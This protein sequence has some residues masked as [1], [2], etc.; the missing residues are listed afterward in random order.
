METLYGKYPKRITCQCNADELDFE[1]MTIYLNDRCPI[2]NKVHQVCVPKPEAVM[3]KLRD[4]DIQA[5]QA[6]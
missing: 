5:K 2:C 3:K 4:I 6:A 1:A